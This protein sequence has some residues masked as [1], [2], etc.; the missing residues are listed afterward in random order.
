M[1][2]CASYIILHLSWM[3]KMM[4]SRFVQQR[5]NYI[6]LNSYPLSI[7]H[8]ATCIINFESYNMHHASC[9]LIGL[10][11]LSLAGCLKIL[12]LSKDTK[13]DVNFMK[14]FIH[15]TSCIKHH[16][17]C[18]IQH[19]SCIMHLDWINVLKRCWVSTDN[20]QGKLSECNAV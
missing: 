1:I 14:L 7:T 6:N 15:Y 9:I 16:E 3:I 13:F 4:I 17:F 12:D 5:M 10:R 11:Y 8:H 2:S 18:I 20:R 19:A